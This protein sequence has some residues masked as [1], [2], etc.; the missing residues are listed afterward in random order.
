MCLCVRVSVPAIT[1]LYLD[2]HGLVRAHKR[3]CIAPPAIRNII[4]YRTHEVL[5]EPAWPHVLT[6]IGSRWRGSCAIGN[7]LV[8][9]RAERQTLD[10][11]RT[12]YTHEMC[13]V[14]FF[15]FRD[16]KQTGNGL[17]SVS[18]LHQQQHPYPRDC[19]VVCGHI[20]LVYTRP[21]VH[22][23]GSPYYL[24]MC[25]NDQVFGHGRQWYRRAR[26]RQ[27]VSFFFSHRTYVYTCCVLLSYI[28]FVKPFRF[29][30]VS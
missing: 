2:R 3:H 16:R 12:M 6:P 28:V 10:L 11:T 15:F 25:K 17:L 30:C 1:N 19:T 4:L 21:H 22:A 20:H 23:R 8:H 27:R 18:F 24:S 7:R 26:N 9:K 5:I 14:S 29:E 13:W